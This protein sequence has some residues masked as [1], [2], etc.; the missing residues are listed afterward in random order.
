MALVLSMI[1]L[2]SSEPLCLSLGSTCLL[3]VIMPSSGGG[4]AAAGDS[5]EDIGMRVMMMVP[6]M[7]METE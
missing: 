7:K 4:G 1:P 5:E 2:S 6:R 3:W